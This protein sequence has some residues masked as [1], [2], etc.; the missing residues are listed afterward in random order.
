MLLAIDV[1]N[2]LID[3]G[4]FDNHRLVRTFKTE[5][6]SNKSMDEYETIIDL[7]VAGKRLDVREINAVIISSVVP[8][9]T[10]VFSGISEKIF[11]VQAVVLGPRLKT[12]LPLKVDHPL[13]V[14]S[15]IVADAV[16]A[17]SLFGEALFIA[18]LG[19]ANKYILLSK[20]KAFAGMS[21]APGLAISMEALVNKTAALPEVS[22]SVPI[23][24]IGK[25]T[26][27]CMNSGIVFGTAFE[28]RGFADAFEKEC[29]YSLKRVLTGGNAVYVKDILPEFVYEE[30]LL[31]KGLDEIFRRKSL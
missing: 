21:I 15:D 16:G 3:F 20:D 10:R 22:M 31:L 30:N 17:S 7:F 25:N 28:A 26:F 23:K 29:G 27:D 13:E 18:D 9:L 11:H 24:V 19:T 12:G 1:G 6:V 4:V 8:S 14:G 2:T 5:T